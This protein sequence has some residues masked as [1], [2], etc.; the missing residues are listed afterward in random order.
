MNELKLK[1][2]G[3]LLFN[4][5]II[6]N[7]SIEIMGKELKLKEDPHGKFT[8][9]GFAISGLI[10]AHTH[11]D[12][13]KPIHSKDF[14]NWIKRVILEDKEIRHEENKS[15]ILKKLKSLGITV[16]YNITRSKRVN[17]KGVINFFEIIGRGNSKIP[18][19]PQ[20]LMLSL[21]APYSVSP[22]F[23]RK[24]IQK[25]PQKAYIMHFLE[26]K[27]EVKFLKGQPNSIEEEIYSIVKRNREH[28]VYKTPAEYLIDINFYGNRKAIVHFV[29]PE[30]EDIQIVKNFGIT[31]I[32]CPRSN[33]YLTG[34]IAPVK[35]LIREGVNLA[36]GTDGLGSTPNLNLWEDMRLLYLIEKI[37]PAT[38][39]KMATTNATK[40]TGIKE[41]VDTGIIIFYT[42]SKKL[43][44]ILLEIL[45]Q[46][47]ELE[48]EIIEPHFCQQP[49]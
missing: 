43:E 30:D 48:K 36:I 49:P 47:E 21:H 23:A 9:S 38:I 1:I 12:F 3:Y 19:I 26:S 16:I 15:R 40:I 32:I 37:E 41:I 27:E 13:S 24:V 11:L 2:E 6:K 42:R 14:V 46:A 10:N 45:F 20:H 28:P 34:K 7:P 8:H 25:Y 29:Y 5:N 44:D 35:D 39:L 31:V 18:N 33:L 22:D 4:G 17:K